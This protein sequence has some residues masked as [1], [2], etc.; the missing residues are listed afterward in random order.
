[1]R[2]FFH[3][4]IH[5]LQRLFQPRQKE[6]TGV[7]GKSG[8][9]R[10]SANR[11]SANRAS[12]SVINSRKPIA[13]SAD[14]E[15]WGERLDERL[16]ERLGERSPADAPNELKQL[17]YQA[18]CQL[19]PNQ[20]LH[21]SR[22]AGLLKQA[23]PSFSYEKYHFTKLIDLLRAVPELVSLE[24]VEPEV[25]REPAPVGETASA[26]RARRLPPV[27][28]VRSRADTTRLIQRGLQ[29]FGDGREWV[30]WQSL[31]EAIAARSPRFEVSRYGFSSF[32]TF[33][34]RRT[35]LVEF[36]SDSPDYVRAIA[37]SNLSAERSAAN[38]NAVQ[39]ADIQPVDIQRTPSNAVIK[40]PPKTTLMRT[41]LE[42]TSS[43]QSNPRPD[44][45]ASA[46]PSTQ[47]SS[48]RSHRSRDRDIESLIKFAGISMETLH[49]KVGDLA[50][51]ALS[52]P[53]YFGAQA[54]DGFAY[55]ILKSYLRYTFVRLQHEDKVMT[56]LNQQYRAFNTGL[57]DTLLRPIYALFTRANTDTAKW[58]LD[59]CIAGEDYTG[60]TLVAEFSQL[61]AAANYFENADKA[62]YH[63]DAGAPTVDWNHV[64]KDN[65][66]RL[67]LS[68]LERY[69][70]NGF[71]PRSTRAMT[72]SEFYEYKRSFIL[73]LDADPSGYR[74]IVS[75]LEEALE[76]TL[77]RTQINYTTAVPTY[78]PKINSV[79][80][81]L[82][83][84][85][86][87]EHTVDLALVVRR[88]PSGRYIGHTILTLRQ[89]YNNARLICKR[90]NH[91]LPRAMALSQHS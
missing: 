36:K 40:L 69:A 88:E 9:N 37:A 45:R 22:I 91:W 17:V 42:R 62:F 33:L 8:A 65:M 66:A 56:S 71:I 59:F 46:R 11:T 72:T 19:R 13:K 50:A 47:A 64:V 53:W 2:A 25:V 58:I 5:F 29:S 75:R 44:I 20:R 34:A 38:S 82:P 21:A 68:F 73:A 27:Y 16:G 79:D 77:R 3:S 14:S 18:T 67:P 30:H 31:E 24:K 55:P 41:R 60:K 89:A 90:D 76:K 70:P 12:Q 7:D 26:I 78:Y 49:Q 1:M 81:L 57:L 86:V 84:C 39:P 74:H 83:M 61:P 15:Q 4:I 51:I 6:S 28:Y 52:E 43:A 80:L 63:L 85:L 48:I 32:K 87:N 54:P 10:T 23:D 35:D